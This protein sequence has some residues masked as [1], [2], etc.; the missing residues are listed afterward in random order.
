MADEIRPQPGPQERAAASPADIVVYG[1]AAGAGKSWWLTYEAA[2]FAHI[3]GYR[4]I[5]FRRTSPEL[6]GGGGLWDE[7][8]DLY[9]LMGAVMREDTMTARWPTGA[10][11]EFRHLQHEKD[12]Y[13]H[14]GRQYAFVGFDELTHFTEGQFWYLVSRMRTTSGVQPYMRC[15]CNP[16]PDSFVRKLVDW[17]IG[18]DG[19]P[20]PDRSGVH[21]WFVRV[22]DAIVWGDDPG[23][24]Q[25]LHPGAEPMSFT[26][27]GATL[28]D[29]KILLKK[30][31]AYRAKLLS[32]PRV[33][34][35]RLLGGNWDVRSAAGD[36]FPKSKFS[37]V[38]EVPS[39]VL[40][41]VR[42]WDKAATTPS[43]NNADPDWTRGAK[44]H[45]HRD[46]SLTIE[47]I[48]GLRK[49]PADVLAA[50]KRMAEQDG[51]RCKVGFWI[52]PGQAGIVDRDATLKELFGWPTAPVRANK[53][54]EAYARAWS[55]LVEAGKVRLVKGP[56]V[57]AFLAE[58]EA[59]PLGGH[60]DQVD[61][62][63]GAVQ[64]L[65][66]SG[67]YALQAAMDRVHAR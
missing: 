47:H 45:R 25:G 56:W 64:V 23:D 2:R 4:G 35:Q 41:T 3:G 42:F 46:G 8:R 9:P 7:A 33:E 43:T 12:K 10:R 55:P 17:W 40:S 52:D 61:A 22:D 39:D 21:R 37:V 13:T 32:L 50:M 15:T 62:V 11:V 57:D 51:K 63:S 31:P 48:E 53:D 34:R 28:D 26:F 54:K 27:I 44:V 6:S 59:F 5:L 24:L 1:G 60:D 14:Q 49:G 20:I 18:E 38:E 36:Y 29:N 16:D 58:S 19:M 66:K 30:D 67:L 65:S